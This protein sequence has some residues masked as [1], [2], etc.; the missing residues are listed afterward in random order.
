MDD[1]GTR[2]EMAVCWAGVLRKEAVETHIAQCV[3]RPSHPSAHLTPP[4]C[5]VCREV[6]S[7]SDECTSWHENPFIAHLRNIE[8][9]NLAECLLF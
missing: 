4:A 1:V 5:S 6:L 8:R 3:V 2:F 7:E 9:Q